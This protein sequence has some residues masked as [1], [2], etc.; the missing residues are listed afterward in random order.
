M[1]LRWV[2]L[3]PALR[4][5]AANAGWLGAEVVVR[6][7]AG[8]AVGVWLTRY[9]GPEGFGFYSYIVALAGLFLPLASLGID[10]IVVRELIAEPGRREE[11]LG[12][13]FLL[14]LVGGSLA[15]AGTVVL[16]AAM[17]PDQPE[18]RWLAG[19]VAMSG[20]FRALDVIDLW[21]QSQVRSKLSVLARSTAFAVASLVKVGL[22]LAGAPV[23]AFA[24][25]LL[26]ESAVVALGLWIAYRGSGERPRAWRPTAEWIRHLA[27]V[28]WPMGLASILVAVYMRI[29]QVLLGQMA[30]NKE[31]GLYATAVR[32]VEFWYFIPSI[33]VTSTFPSVMEAR[34]LGDDVF[35]ARLQKLYNLLALLSYA[36]AVP[37]TLLAGW[38]VPLVFGEAYREAASMLAVLVWSLVFTSLGVAR[39]AF[40]TAMNWTRA[41]LVTVALGC[42]VNIALNLLL[43]PRMGG[44]GAVVASCVAYWVAAHGSCFLIPSLHRTGS[45][46]TRAMI[47]PVP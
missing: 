14:R 2:P 12:S 38:V 44:M 1:G 29:D 5:I 11:T 30:G 18:A 43:I 42:A 35:Y 19:V 33:I 13:A 41:Y 20:V 17:R 46:L 39:G 37:T 26:L 45:M 8:F 23:A 10:R 15:L 28:G 25:V 3:R 7:A 4:R 21:F 9:L 27:R 31:V 47:R 36:I 6:L 22:I 34:I 16:A 40:L 32:L 24:W